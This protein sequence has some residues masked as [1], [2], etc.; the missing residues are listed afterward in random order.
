M[1]ER[2]SHYSASVNKVSNFN[3]LDSH[4]FVTRCGGP[5]PIFLEVHLGYFWR[6]ILDIF[7]GLYMLILTMETRTSGSNGFKRRQRLWSLSFLL[8]LVLFLWA[9][10]C[11]PWHGT[12]VAYHCLVQ[13]D[14]DCRRNVKH[15]TRKRWLAFDGCPCAVQHNTYVQ[16]GSATKLTSVYTH[17]KLAFR[18]LFC[19]N[20]PKFRIHPNITCSKNLTL[21]SGNF[22][23]T[24]YNVAL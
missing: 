19:T 20:D 16:R 22:E 4:F 23:F 10:S 17:C 2:S 18:F 5:S 14:D 11:L 13:G 24:I 12:P 7:G 8:F 6:S 21:N 1:N 3:V 15:Q 9:S